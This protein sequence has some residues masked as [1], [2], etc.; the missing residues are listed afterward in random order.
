MA[1][2]P[3]EFFKLFDDNID[4]INS[5]L[6]SIGRQCGHPF[7]CSIDVRDSLWKTCGVDVNLFPGGFNNVPAE[8]R[9]LAAQ[10]VKQFFSA[11]LNCPAPWIITLVPEGHTN[12]KGYLE[13]LC[14]LRDLLSSAGCQ[15]NIIWPDHNLPQPWTLKTPM[16]KRELTYLPHSEALLNSQALILNHDL[17]RGLPDFVKKSTLPCYPS[18]NLGWYRRKKSEHFTIV[19]SILNKIKENLDWFDPWFF[20]PETIRFEFDILSEDSF[21]NELAL[22]FGQLS[23][24]ISEQYANRSIK[25]SPHIF[26]KD[27]SGTY[28][29]GVM[30]L[31]TNTDLFSIKNQILKKFNYSKSKQKTHEIILQES[32][33]TCFSDD[34]ATL[35]PVL[36]LV[37]G[38]I[39]GSFMRGHNKLK[40]LSAES[41]ANLNQPGGFFKAIN[42]D[43]NF[44][45]LPKSYPYSSIYSPTNSRYKFLA[46]LHSTAAGMEDCL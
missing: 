21:I 17:S 45:K 12:N 29:L 2:N 13:N 43:L 23:Q 27:N 1:L 31:P 28:G 6:N 11:K 4:N 38:T 10:K 30:S 8:Q 9:Q 36:Y 32:I 20:H 19:H 25:E 3:N 37:N 35:E 24:T 44:S 34:K 7:Y 46:K 16:S 18:K 26:L 41:Q 39:I 33:P 42:K 5:I 40:S 14:D 22:K 15:V